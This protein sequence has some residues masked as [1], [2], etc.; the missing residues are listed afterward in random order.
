MRL[1]PYFWTIVGL[2]FFLR[3]ALLL[4][5]GPA[6]QYAFTPDSASYI[7]P[8]QQLRLTGSFATVQD[9]KEVPELYRTPGYPVFLIPFLSKD[10]LVHHRRVQWAQAL[11]NA[12]SAGLIY[13][14]ALAFWQNRTAALA[15]GI[16]FALD[17]VNAIHGMFVLTDIVFVFLVS[18]SLLFIVRREYVYAG[19][20][21]ALAAFVRP[22]GLY[23][24]GFLALL[25]A[26]QWLRKKSDPSL[27][28]VVLFLMVSCLPLTVWMLRNQRAA[29]RF[30]FTT[31]Q[32]ANIY[33]LRA[34]LVKMEREHVS[35]ESAVEQLQK[36]LVGSPTPGTA[37]PRANR[38]LLIYWRDYV[39]VMAKDV[40]KLF[41][42]N[43]MKVAA[44]AIL[45]DDHYSPNAVPVHSTQSPMTQARELTARHPLLGVGLVVYLV[46]L[47]VVYFLAAGGFAVAVRD[48]GWGE[49]ILALSSVLYF[50]AITLGV[51]AQARYRLPI[52]PALFLFAGGGYRM[53]FTKENS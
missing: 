34:A 37:D 32:D 25:L 6:P 18:V 48:K 7:L 53:L 24:P 33:L 29:G 21:T 42:G 28:H 12:L 10:G 13:L 51:D 40:V 16:G 27:K 26:G 15:A 1:D 2:S 14:A 38:Y 23:Y 3:A 45:K 44:W 49:S 47:G 46:F 50:V 11:L 39:T 31:L 17:F 43:S 35:Y 8:A 30:T 52:M 5:I 19:V 4:G 9:G 36:P 20:A 22:I 41:T